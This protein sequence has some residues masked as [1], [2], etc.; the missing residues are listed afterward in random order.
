MLD[1]VED[2]EGESKP[3]E[4]QQER[5]EQRMPQAPLER[6]AQPNHGSMVD[7]P[8]RQVADAGAGAG[9]GAGYRCVDL[10]EDAGEGRPGVKHPQV[11]AGAGE[12]AVGAAEKA[13]DR[14]SIRRR[15]CRTMRQ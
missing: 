14:A 15:P 3:E 4:E 6:L 11:A 1:R 5:P 10:A 13:G 8:P 12:L 7:E 9:L 2:H